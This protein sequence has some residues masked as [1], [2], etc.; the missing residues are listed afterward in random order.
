MEEAE[1]MHNGASSFS[2]K[3]DEDTLFHYHI[4]IPVRFQVRLNPAF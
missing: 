3:S 1:G 2:E 4:K